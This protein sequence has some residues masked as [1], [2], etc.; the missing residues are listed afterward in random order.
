MSK[1]TRT[2]PWLRIRV[3]GDRC[4]AATWRWQAIAEGSDGLGEVPGVPGN[5]GASAGNQPRRFGVPAAQWVQDC[6]IR[7]HVVEDR[8]ACPL[9]SIAECA[10]RFRSR[11]RRR[12]Q[13][14]SPQVR[15]QYAYR[16]LR[17]DLTTRTEFAKTAADEPLILS[18]WTCVNHQPW[19]PCRTRSSLLP[20]RSALAGSPLVRWA[21][22]SPQC[23]PLAWLRSLT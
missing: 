9:A 11:T 23:S 18:K 13:L 3:C 6:E 17:K 16:P 21:G 7:R 2:P 20:G 22:F 19:F 15:R 5:A 10:V 4:V 1:L 14:R 8:D 12:W